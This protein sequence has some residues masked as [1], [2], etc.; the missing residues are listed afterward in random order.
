MEIRVKL[1]CYKNGREEAIGVS[2]IIE[3]KLK[4]KYS[5]NNISILLEQF[6]KPENLKKDF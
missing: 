3:K 4:K 2:D 6:F 5:L 1:T